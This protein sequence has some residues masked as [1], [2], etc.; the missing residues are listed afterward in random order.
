MRALEKS[1]ARREDRKYV[2][3][4]K[5]PEALQ[6]VS[7]RGSRVTDA[8]GRT[9]IDLQMGWCVGNLGWNHPA[10][11]KRLRAFEGP[12]YVSP[13]MM[14]EPWTALAR[15]L[16]QITPGG[17]SRSY[18]AVSG[19][20][21]NEL[22]LQLA[23]AATGRT[24]L[25]SIAGAYHG[26]SIL[27]K[28]IGEGG[29]V[30]I[31]SCKKLA[32]PLDAKALDRLETILKHRDVAAFILEPV[33]MNLGV[34]IP[35]DEFLVGA[36]A[37]CDRYGTLLVADEVASGW[38]RTGKLFAIEHSGVVPDIM[39]LA[40]AITNGVAPLAA[41]IT[42]PALADEVK[43]EL[44][45]YS[46]FGWL[47]LA[48]EAALATIA[49]HRAEGEAIADN[50]AR[51]SGEVL[52]RLLAMRWQADAEIRIRGLAIA[53]KLDDEDYIRRIAERCKRAGLIVVPEDEYLV[54]LP[55]VTISGAD[56]AEALDILEHAVT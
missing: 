46:T 45:F 15:E 24:K 31:P 51:R 21:A 23:M 18:R 27:V 41:A 16:A 7:A 3:R 40:K 36:R 1:D 47:P 54:L 2:G 50:V 28:S 12:S 5:D 34:E 29:A 4:T 33:I 25:V 56:M 14:Y 26:N 10:I 6:I 22:A 55:A 32:P 52:S 39:T 44:E 19:T 13:S 11:A 37:L 49:V 42:T 9:F 8:K 38:A 20:E 35:T 17:L 48:T 53:V 30:T 43:G